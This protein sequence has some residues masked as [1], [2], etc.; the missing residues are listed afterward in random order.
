MTTP[1]RIVIGPIC[2]ANAENSTAHQLAK[3][4]KITLQNVVSVEE[5][6]PQIRKA[7]NIIIT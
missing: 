6:I 4:V 2:V 5:H 7:L 3:I 1:K